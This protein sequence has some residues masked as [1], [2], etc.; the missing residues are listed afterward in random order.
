MF[1]LFSCLYLTRV[2]FLQRYFSETK[3]KIDSAISKAEEGWG[4]GGKDVGNRSENPYSLDYEQSL[5]CRTARSLA[6]ATVA[7]S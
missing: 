6:P 3:L 7:Q 1:T 5:C 4:G 2:I